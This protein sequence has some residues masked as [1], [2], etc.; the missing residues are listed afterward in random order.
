MNS[1]EGV[2]YYSPALPALG[3]MTAM[4]F[5]PVRDDAPSSS[6]PGLSLQVY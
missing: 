1:P 5:S 6:Y 3:I 4:I 2:T